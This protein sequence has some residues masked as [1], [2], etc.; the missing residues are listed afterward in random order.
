[1]F[2]DLTDSE[3]LELNNCLYRA[4]M[5]FPKRYSD[6]DLWLEVYSAWL[7]VNL[8]MLRRRRLKE[9]LERV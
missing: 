8:E 1:M 5:G 4:R 2:E 9:R 6:Y 3:L 7:D